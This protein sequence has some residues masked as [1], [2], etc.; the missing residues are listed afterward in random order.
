MENRKPPLT[1]LVVRAGKGIPGGGFIAWD[2]DDLATA[3]ANVF[4]EDW[5]KTPNPFR[6]FGPND[7]I[8]RWGLQLA[9]KPNHGEAIL[10]KVKDRGIFQKIFRSALIEIYGGCAVCGLTFYDALD[11]AHIL[12][13]S[14]CSPHERADVRNGVLLC[15]THHRLFDSQWIEISTDHR[16]TFSDPDMKEGGDYSKI[17]KTLTVDYHG[18]T[19]ALPENRTLAPAA[20]YLMRRSKLSEHETVDS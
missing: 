3:Q 19:I 18:K 5:A 13:W 8:E 9:Q 4:D 14:F 7:T 12:P 6:S 16:I 10:R 2:V 1:A 20:T 17:D 11:A 15:A